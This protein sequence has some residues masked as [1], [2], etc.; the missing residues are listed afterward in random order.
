MSENKQCSVATESGVGL[1]LILALFPQRISIKTHKTV[2][3]LR[4]RNKKSKMGHRAKK[5]ATT[6]LTEVSLFLGAEHPEAC[7]LCCQES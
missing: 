5:I 2:I 4:V 6:Y 1:R 7:I 3:R